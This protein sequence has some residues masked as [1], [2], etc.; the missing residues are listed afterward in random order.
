LF[1]KWLS[2]AI[3][4]QKIRITIKFRLILPF[5][6]DSGS[7]LLERANRMIKYIFFSFFY[8]R[9]IFALVLF[10]GYPISTNAGILDAVS[11]ISVAG[12]NTSKVK[13]ENSQTIELPQAVLNPNPSVGGGDITI[14]DKTALMADSGQPGGDMLDDSSNGQISIYVVRKG[15]TLSEIAKMYGVSVNTII[16]GND[17]KNSI[18]SEGQTLTILPVSGVKHIVKA[19]DTMKSIANKYNGDIHD[20]LDYNGLKETSKLSVGDVVIIPGGEVRATSGSSK[21]PVTKTYTKEYSGYYIRPIAGGVKTQGLHGYNGIDLASSIGTP[22]MASAGGQVIISK[23]SGYNGGYGQYI[24]VKHNN[25]TQTLYAHLSKNNVSQG[26]TVTQGETI[27]LMGSTGHST[28]S[29]VHFEIR[30]AKNPF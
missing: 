20:I 14:V 25:G 30:G 7:K 16:W 8:L 26:D 6:N 13:I 4:F 5:K 17:L 2:L 11:N 1:F 18:L 3:Y 12:K 28:G 29:H 27:G 15:D 23:T 19:G 10:G 24:V 21:T 9:L 22:I